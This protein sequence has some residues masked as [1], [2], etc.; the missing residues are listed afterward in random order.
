MLK[1]SMVL[2]A[3]FAAI[4]TGVAKADA[5]TEARAALCEKV[6]TCAMEQMAVEQDMNEQMRTM[7]M[8]S[9]DSMCVSMEQGFSV[10]TRAHELYEPAT[11]CMN[12]MVQ[13]SCQTLIENGDEQTPECVAFREEA[14]KYQ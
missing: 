9:L 13:L 4:P 10:V 12:S 14:R 6:K 2:I 5:F 11:A 8:N 3:M 1:K 7:L